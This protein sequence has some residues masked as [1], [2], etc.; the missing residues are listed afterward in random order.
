MMK[1]VWGLVFV[2]CLVRATLLGLAWQGNADPVSQE[3]VLRHFTAEDIERGRAYVKNGF[4]ARFVYGYMQLAVLLLLW[5]SGWLK[6]LEARLEAALPGGFWIAGAALTLVVLVVARLSMLPLD[7][8]LGY[9]CEQRMGFSEMTAA[10]WAWR[11]AKSCLV[12]WS[13]QTVG[14]LV[15]LGVLKWCGSWWPLLLPTATT[16][17][18]IVLTLLM[19]YLIT[20]LFYE[21]KPLAEGPLRSRILE[22]AAKAEVP[23][24]DI[25]EI[26]ESRYS[27]HTNAYFTGLFGKRRIVLYDTLIKSHTVD[28]AALI[29]AHEAGHWRHDHVRIGLTLGFLGGLLG[30]AVLWWLYPLIAAEPAMRLGEIWR[31]SNLPFFFAASM[32]L[33][34]L[35][36]PVEAQISQAFERQADL[37][38][39]ELTGLAD[40]FIDAEKRLARDNR[41]DLLPHPW[42][43][44]WL[45]SH[46]PAIDRIAMGERFRNESPA[47]ASVTVK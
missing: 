5:R 46:P 2:W 19:P 4:G 23:V 41:S 7:Y 43:V 17:Y 22:I 16:A 34:L 13:F 1:W 15:A 39:L 6:L 25:Y 38:S 8:Y 30:A 29:F 14:I 10:Q 9:V 26:D 35:A 21:Q 24:D 27:K 33:G 42:R 47:S 28:E 44:F 11:Y 20:P 31:A 3:R 45:Y 36:A 18:G 32:V 37:A 12:G 40:V